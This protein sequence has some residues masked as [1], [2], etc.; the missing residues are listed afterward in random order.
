MTVGT[1]FEIFG[2]EIGE[3]S[4]VKSLGLMHDVLEELYDLSLSL[5][6]A[7]ITLPATSELISYSVINQL[8]CARRE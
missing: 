4:F 8:F 2:Q 5:Q 6:K 1:L 3:S 7:D